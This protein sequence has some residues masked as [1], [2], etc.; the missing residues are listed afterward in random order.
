MRKHTQRA[1][2]R[3]LHGVGVALTIAS[4]ALPMAARAAPKGEI[5][6][7][8]SV[9]SQRFDPTT[10]AQVADS[11]T[12]DFLFDG[13]INV[14]AEGKKPALA[15]S[16]T[17]SPDGKQVDF[18]LREG[19]KFHNGDPFTAAD[20]KFTFESLAKAGSTHIYAKVYNDTIE[21]VDVISP[22]QARFVLKQPWPSFFTTS[23]YAM[24]AVVPKAYYEKVGAKGFMEKP[25]G[26][27]PFTL[28]GLQSGEWTKYEANPAY[29]GQVSGP[30]FVTQRLVKEP[31]TRYA[32]L[33]KGEADIVMGITGP[34][35]TRV[36]DD[37]KVRLFW[38]KYSGVSGL[39]FNKNDFPQ[40][41]DIRV[42]MAI[43]HSID[44]EGMAKTILGGVCTPATE[45]F[46]PATFGFL[47]GL[48]PIP[49]DMAKAKE[50]IKAA[51]GAQPQEITFLLITEAPGS[52]PGAPQVMEAIA[53]TIGDLGFKLKRIPVEF[54]A[55][56]DIFRK[57]QEPGIFSGLVSIPDDGG[58]IVN[59]WYTATA[60]WAHGHAA[61]PEYEKIAVEQ[62]QTPSP[63]KRE[64]LLQE[65]AKLED[66]SKE[67]IPLFW[68]DTPFA[69]GPRIKNWKPSVGSPY[70]LQLNTVELA[71]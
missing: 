54:G 60:V 6:L 70:Q 44:R 49:Y 21:R 50:L 55:Y 13:L 62:R 22:L 45:M 47:P 23:R 16:W 26:T 2:R 30:Q 12:Y 18:M 58:Q 20:V 19:I 27:G 51:G 52:L 25:V 5:T 59:D 4:L 15:K 29:W 8:T 42:R 14:G 11:M 1:A 37:P 53:S 24:Q 64:K 57:Q 68:C 41:K 63:E 10:T 17:I 36:R 65:F 66:E 48:K 43:A 3:V 35:L 56:V 61:K 69:A 38:S 31:F 32:M 7:A 39:F 9:L 71:N 40:A 34:L 46:T 67:T 33:Q 28:V